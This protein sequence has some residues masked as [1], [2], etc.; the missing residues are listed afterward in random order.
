M[1]DN[2]NDKRFDSACARA[3]FGIWSLLWIVGEEPHSC[4]ALFMIDKVFHTTS[5]AKKTAFTFH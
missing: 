3:I 4:R 2:G 5:Q 1:N